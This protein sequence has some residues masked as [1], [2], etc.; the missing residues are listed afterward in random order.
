MQNAGAW[1]RIVWKDA[2]PFEL[3]NKYVSKNIQSSVKFVIFCKIME[4][5]LLFM[6]FVT[7]G[8]IV[9]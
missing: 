9:L 8:N 3:T 6:I 7:C 1:A 5:N 4:Q 2:C